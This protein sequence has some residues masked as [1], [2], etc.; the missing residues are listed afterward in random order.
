[1]VGDGSEIRGLGGDD[2]VVPDKRDR[3]EDNHGTKS[4]DGLVAC[5]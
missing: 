1:M 3:I 4:C 5:A 2:E